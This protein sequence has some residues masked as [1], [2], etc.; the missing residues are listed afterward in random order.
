MAGSLGHRLPQVFPVG[1][2]PE[3]VVQ[4]SLEKASRKTFAGLFRKLATRKAHP[5]LNF[6]NSSLSGKKATNPSTPW[7]SL[8]SPKKASGSKREP[9]PRARGAG[10]RRSARRGGGSPPCPPSGGR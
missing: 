10:A 2:G 9:A 3:E 1:Q 7:R 5:V 4:E 6:T 8:I